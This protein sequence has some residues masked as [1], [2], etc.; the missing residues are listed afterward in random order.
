MSKKNKKDPFFYFAEYNINVYNHVWWIIFTNDIDAH[1]KHQ[2]G[3]DFKFTKKQIKPWLI[4]SEDVAAQVCVFEEKKLH[5][6]IAIFNIDKYKNHIGVHEAFHMVKKTLYPRGLFL[7]DTSSSEEPYAYL[8]G[9]CYRA[10]D[11][12]YQGAKTNYE[13]FKNK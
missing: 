1:L 4:A 3:I 7:D 12:V 10:I 8:L 11:D 13:T 6:S 5:C 2:L 9:D